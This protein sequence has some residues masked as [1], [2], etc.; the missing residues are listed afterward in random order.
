MPR[1]PLTNVKTTDEI[2]ETQGAKK[3]RKMKTL[4]SYIL[5]Y[6]CLAFFILVLIYIGEMF[7]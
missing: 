1:Y 2:R 7:V 6:V 4:V 3:G 5:E